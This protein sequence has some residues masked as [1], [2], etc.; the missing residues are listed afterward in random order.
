MLRSESLSSTWLDP[1]CSS[2]LPP[3]HWCC[4]REP[5]SV[6]CGPTSVRSS[7]RCASSSPHGFSGGP[8]HGRTARGAGSR[9]VDSADRDAGGLLE[10]FDHRRE[11]GIEPL[12]ARGC[13]PERS[14]RF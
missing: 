6:W 8:L 1:F 14:D 4:A 11:I 10:R 3:A 2:S 5:T 7:V 13:L 9:R 12:V